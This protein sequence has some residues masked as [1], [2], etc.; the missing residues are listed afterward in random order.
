MTRE[1]LLVT[2]ATADAATLAKIKRAL[3]NHEGDNTDRLVRLDETARRLGI[4]RRSVTSL[5]ADGSLPAVRLPGRTRVIG[6]R[7]SAIVALIEGRA[8]QHV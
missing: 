3:T 2:V 5:L 6:T 7:E 4:S 1:K 8:E